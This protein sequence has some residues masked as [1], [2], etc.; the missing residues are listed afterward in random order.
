MTAQILVIMRKEWQD[1]KSTLFSYTHWLAGLWP[2]LLF[3]AAFGVYEPLR[4]GADWLQ[5]PGMVLSISVLV[6]FVVIGSISPYAF[7]GERVRGT[8]EALLATPVSDRALLFGKIAAAVLF[9]W[10]LALVSLLLGA[11][12]IN[13]FL[14][15]SRLLFYPP[16]ILISTILLSL[17][18]SILVATLGTAAS[19]Y[20]KTFLEAQ[21]KLV[22]GLLLPMLL[23]AFWIGPL[24]PAA[25]KGLVVQV[26]PVLASAPLFPLLL[27]LLLVLDGIFML[28]A[29]TRFHRKLLLLK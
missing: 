23:P 8:L 19:F 13:F 20:A 6:P 25:W 1:N 10:G 18:F 28:S 2:V 9:G 11:G 26:L 7:V 29:V 4:V 22:L 21:R 14:V 16:G 12:S 5:S 27:V 15:H 17:F 3:C 24:M